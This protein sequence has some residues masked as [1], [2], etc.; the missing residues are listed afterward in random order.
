MKLTP[1]NEQVEYLKAL[2]VLSPDDTALPSSA[3]L[4]ECRMHQ[5]PPEPVNAGGIGK[6]LAG[7]AAFVLLVAVLV[8][9]LA[10]WAKPETISTADSGTAS[11]LLDRYVASV[12]APE[13]VAPAFA[14]LRSTDHLEA[15]QAFESAYRQGIDRLALYLALISIGSLLLWFLAQRYL[16][17]ISLKAIGHYLSWSELH[18]GESDDDNRD[19]SIRQATSISTRPRRTG[20]LSVIHPEKL[21]ETLKLTPTLGSLDRVAPKLPTE[22]WSLGYATHAGHVRS[23]NQDYVAAFNF[24]GRD[25]VIIAD[26]MGGLKHGREASFLAV[27]AAVMTVITQLSNPV[28]RRSARPEKIAAATLAQA[29]LALATEADRFG[30]TDID[31]GLR[32]TLI[33][34]VAQKAQVGY[35]YIGD[36]GGWLV[37]TSGEVESFLTPQKHENAANVLSA[38]LGP[39]LQGS[40]ASGTFERAFGDVVIVCT[41]GIADRIDPATFLNNV[42]TVGDQTGGDFQSLSAKVVSD[43]ASA[44]DEAGF[45]C[46]DNLTIGMIG[47]GDRPLFL[48]GGPASTER[49]KV[50]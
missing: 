13:T 38:S 48:A 36:G 7:L 24:H 41:D 40:S 32:T 2:G 35:A 18:R 4:R 47:T 10:G 42:M 50:G 3:P 22:P 20:R 49:E 27:R 21:L 11:R 9:L 33:V 12:S 8:M 34:V 14:T 17:S 19:G 44:T 16:L 6:R 31:D 26:G 5:N 39:T 1:S 45:I 43:L 46:D 29:H 15:V 28:R 23:E 37:R 25:I 30:V